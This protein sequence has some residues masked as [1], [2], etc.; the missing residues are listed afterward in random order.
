MFSENTTYEKL[1]ENVD[2]IPHVENSS[3]EPSIEENLENPQEEFKDE[4]QE[5]LDQLKEPEHP[6]SVEIKPSEPTII[7]E[8]VVA[9]NTAN[10]CFMGCSV[11]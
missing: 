9:E 10:K 7:S 11:M 1:E 3:V 5:L 6:P 4:H 2:S 8:P